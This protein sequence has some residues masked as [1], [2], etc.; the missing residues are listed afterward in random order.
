[1]N[2]FKPGFFRLVFENLK[3]EQFISANNFETNEHALAASEYYTNGNFTSSGS[4]VV[5]S[6]V[7]QELIATTKPAL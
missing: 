7:C 5:G 6:Y 2:Q 4:K 1:M 3:G